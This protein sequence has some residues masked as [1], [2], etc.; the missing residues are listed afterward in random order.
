MGKKRA[1]GFKCRYNCKNLFA[2]SQ[3]RSCHYRRVHPEKYI[4]DKNKRFN[5]KFKC[6][7]CPKESISEKGLH[8]HY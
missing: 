6:P 2:S 1:L 5:S 3:S 4:E 7:V 8:K